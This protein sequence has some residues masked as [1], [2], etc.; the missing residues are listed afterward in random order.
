MQKLFYI[1]LP[2]NSFATGNRLYYCINSD[3]FLLHF[4]TKYIHYICCLLLLVNYV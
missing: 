3:T 1:V 2:G 4:L